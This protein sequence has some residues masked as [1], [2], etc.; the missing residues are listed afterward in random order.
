LRI[1]GRPPIARQRRPVQHEDARHLAARR[2]DLAARRK[3]RQHR[4]IAAHRLERIHDAHMRHAA[5]RLEHVRGDRDQ[6]P[7]PFQDAPDILQRR[8]TL[9][10]GRWVHAEPGQRRSDHAGEF[11]SLGGVERARR[12]IVRHQTG[13]FQAL[14]HRLEAEPT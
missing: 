5:D 4:R 6:R 9:R 10:V 7:R 2:L 8:R 14:A 13:R 1:T 12:D 3:M 11:L